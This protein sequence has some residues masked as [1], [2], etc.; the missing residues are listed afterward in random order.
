MR[1][2]R[3]RSNC[4][5][6][7]TAMKLMSDEGVSSA[8]VIEEDTGILLSA[9]SV[10]DIGKIVVPSE[11]NQILSAPLHQ[12]IAQIKEP[13]GSTDG[14]DQYPVYFVLPSSSLSYTIQKLLATNA[15]RLFVARSP[16]RAASPGL[17]LGSVGNLT[18]I[19]SVV[20]ILS[21][22]A[23]LAHISDIDPARMQRHRRA[24]SA[25][26]QSSKVD[27]ARS[28]S[29]SRTSITNSPILRPVNP[30]T[31]ESVRNS[32]SSIES[33]QWTERVAGKKE[34]M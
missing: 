18:G 2:N 5:T 7:L 6:V 1:S 32:V 12:F 15:H 21:L 10:T 27:L 34:S 22:F 11:S 33:F 16:S 29:G 25:S 20:D 19:V 28:R 24:S 4:S 30:S 26:S 8:A 14:V 3:P 31:G 23:R 13:Y 17:S 9:V